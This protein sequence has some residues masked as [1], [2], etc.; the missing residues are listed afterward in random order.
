MIAEIL[1][2][3]HHI[4]VRSFHGGVF[5]HAIPSD[6]ETDEVGKIQYSFCKHKH[7]ELWILPDSK[8]VIGWVFCW[9]SRTF[10]YS[11]YEWTPE[12]ERATEYAKGTGVSL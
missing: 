9:D 3:Q 11:H 8:A 6:K 7:I 5:Q 10:Y 1:E 2:A 4:R 12:M